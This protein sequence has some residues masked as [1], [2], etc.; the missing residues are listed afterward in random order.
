M[1]EW[2]VRLLCPSPRK[3]YCDTLMSDRHRG[4]LWRV[5]YIKKG[6]ILLTIFK[7]AHF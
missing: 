1:G 3:I 4:A 7:T 2:H 5:G 6:F